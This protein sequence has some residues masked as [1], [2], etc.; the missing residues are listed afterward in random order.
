MKKLTAPAKFALAMILTAAAV[1]GCKKQDA[2]PVTPETKI[3]ATPD[4]GNI[5]PPVPGNELPAPAAPAPAPMP[6]PQAN[7][8]ASH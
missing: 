7:T 4:A 6:M 8:P 5:T 2:D 3:G 1:T